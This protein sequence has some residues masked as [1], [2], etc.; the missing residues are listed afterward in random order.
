MQ[1]RLSE[2]TL[3]EEGELVLVVAEQNEGPDGKHPYVRTGVR[4]G[5]VFYEDVERDSLPII[6]I[7]YWMP[8]PPLPPKQA[9]N[10][11]TKSSGDL[12]LP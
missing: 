7:K 8:F 10:S 12:E 4:L 3:P 2:Y 9:L 6:P 1:W 5:N 11:D